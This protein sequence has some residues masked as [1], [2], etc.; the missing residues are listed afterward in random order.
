MQRSP[1]Q[2]VAFVLQWKR[3]IK[4]K[5]ETEWMIPVKQIRKITVLMLAVCLLT[6]A[7]SACG[8]KTGG[9]T[10]ATTQTTALPAEALP[11]H[12]QTS[13]VGLQTISNALSVA[14]EPNAD[15]FTYTISDGTVTL[16]GYLGTF[17]NIRIPAEIE[18]SPVTAI[19][20]GAFENAEQLHVLVIPDTVLSIG[21]GILR[22][23]GS[24]VALQTPLLGNS[25]ASDQYL[26]Y[27]FGS[28]SYEENSRDVPVS[29]KYLKLTGS[30][31]SLAKFA[32]YDCNDLVAIQ[33]PETMLSL[34]PYSLFRCERLQFINTSH[35]Q[36]VSERA[37]MQCK[38]LTSL[39]FG[40]ALTQ[41]G[42]GALEGCS[43]LECLTLPFIGGS[44]TENRYLAYLFGAAVP[45]FSAG[46]YPQSLI[47]VRLL[48]TCVS[49]GNYA[50]YECSRLVYLTLEEGITSIGVR[51]FDGCERLRSLILPNTLQS[52]GE[53]AFFD[54]KRLKTVSFGTAEDSRLSQIGINAFYNCISLEQ[55]VL[56]QSLESIPASCFAGC[57]ALR[58]VQLGGVKTVGKNAFRGC[59]SLTE[60]LQ[61]GDVRFEEGNEAA[62]PKD[63]D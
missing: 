40:S 23:C 52:I 21:T 57:T 24:I 37:M 25:A 63:T 12:P 43:S 51:A 8:T 10:S 28:A 44:A 31:P 22:G 50:F 38:A 60:V 9:T 6:V 16:T 59:T 47:E 18:G 42:L 27:L 62:L 29:L 32:L 26:G 46:Y 41:I 14:V 7:F 11:P 48:S 5:T 58:S 34:E 2:A 3:Q 1:C 54:C 55:V 36:T 20:G 30:A 45:D 4:D 56:P 39:E 53:N 61:N 17:S 19:A 35:L 33:L 49:L 15:Q 13:A